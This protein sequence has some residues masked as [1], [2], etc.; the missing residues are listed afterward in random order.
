MTDDS[1]NVLDPK[2]NRTPAEVGRA[3]FR[4]VREHDAIRITQ[5]ESEW[6][7]KIVPEDEE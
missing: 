7:V 5:G 4:L 6:D 3:V 2:T 1:D